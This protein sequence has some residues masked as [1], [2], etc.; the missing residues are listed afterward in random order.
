MLGVL[1]CRGAELGDVRRS[2]RQEDLM[3]A[4]AKRPSVPIP[5]AMGTEART[6]AYYR[7]IR[8]PCIRASALLEPHIQ[9]VAAEVAGKV[10]L[11]V[12]DSTNIEHA[13]AQGAQREHMHVAAQHEA[14][15]VVGRQP[16][17]L[18]QNM[19]EI[20]QGDIA[21]AQQLLPGQATPP[22]QGGGVDTVLLEFSQ[23]QS[24]VDGADRFH[25]QNLAILA[26]YDTFLAQSALIIHIRGAHSTPNSMT[27]P[28]G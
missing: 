28:S 10:V 18:A 27:D 19:Q 6:E 16:L 1:G 5:Q 17:T 8:N 12:H 21:A 9:D 20:N 2:R 24:S 7:F 22:E 13:C 26:N 11:A 14:Q 3:R 23:Y 4:L 25:V 15:P